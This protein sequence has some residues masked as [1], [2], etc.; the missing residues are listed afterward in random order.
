M[1]TKS[2]QEEL[3]LNPK[4][5]GDHHRLLLLRYLRLHG[6]TSRADLAR[7]LGLAPSVVSRLVRE[8]LA[9]GCLVEREC[10]KTPLGRRP[11]L[12][13][14]NPDYRTVIGAHIQTDKLECALLNLGGHVL[15]RWESIIGKEPGPEQVFELLFKAVNA[16][17][18]E[19]T[20]G[21][22]VAISGLIDV[23]TGRI[24]FSPVLQWE[25]INI[26][27]AL[28]K[29]CA[30]PVHV[31]NDANALA[32]AELLHGAGRN[33]K[34]FLC[35]MISDGL[36]GGVVLEGRLYRGM[37]GGAGELGHTTIDPSDGASICRCGERGCL[38]EFCSKRALNKEAQR[39]GLEDWRTLGEMA[40]RGDTHAQKAFLRF[41]Y[42]LG[43][44]LKN[45]VNL[46]NPEA[47]II[48]GDLAEFADLFLHTAKEVVCKHC[49]PGGRTAPEIVLWQVGKEGFLVGAGGL[50]VEEFLSSPIRA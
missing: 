21:I 7:S 10:P 11:T 5:M 40:R 27:E 6:P 24:V 25:G 33:Y 28:E 16:L 46:L 23:K 50:V 3:V 4:V 30:L 14:F 8:L 22:G 2:R 32:V 12:L 18:R 39:L 41:G 43:L 20:L 17:R 34:D 44:G 9:E 49:F 48:G 31:E 1:R 45:A 37:L 26:R 36:G 42:F 13:A 15:A 19:N 38:E 29:G 35:V 47:V